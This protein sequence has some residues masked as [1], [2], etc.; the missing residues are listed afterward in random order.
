MRAILDLDDGEI[1]V[2]SYDLYLSPTTGGGGGAQGET[3]PEGPEGP[4]GPIGPQGP[5]GA[6]GA[7]GPRG[8]RGSDGAD[9]L[10]G[11]IGPEGPEGPEGLRGPAGAGEDTGWIRVTA[12]EVPRAFDGGGRR[13]MVGLPLP[14]NMYGKGAL[15]PEVHVRRQGGLVIWHYV[16]VNTEGTSLFTLPDGFGALVTKLEVPIGTGRK[17]VSVDGTTMTLS[18][19]MDASVEGF[20]LIYPTI[21]PFPT[22]LPVSV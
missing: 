13:K 19:Y 12:A 20:V 22:T 11:Y 15:D 2:G 10:N 4:R 9:G 6:D 14:G 1:P 18:G 5:A 17:T 8:Y 16:G 3:G 7:Q 21:V